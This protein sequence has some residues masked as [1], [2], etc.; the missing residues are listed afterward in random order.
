MISEIRRVVLT[1]LSSFLRQYCLVFT[2]VT[3]ALEVF[4]NVMRYINLRFTYLL[5][6]LLTLIAALVLTKLDFGN[7][8]AAGIQ[9][10][11]LIIIIITITRSARQ[12]QT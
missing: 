7:A 11:Q 12:S 2:N 8:I 5:T 3:S 4:L 9:S 1:V 6:Y 10:F